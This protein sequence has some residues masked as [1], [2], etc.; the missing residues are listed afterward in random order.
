MSESEAL[1]RTSCRSR[2]SSAE[3]H[4][5]WLL[6]RLL[7]MSSGHARFRALDAAGLSFFASAFAARLPLIGSSISFC[8]AAALR[9]FLPFAGSAPRSFAMLRFRASI[10]ST[11]FSDFGRAFNGLAATVLID[12]LGQRSFV[13]ILKFLGLECGG[14]LIDDMPGEIEHNRV[15]E[16]VIETGSGWTI[17]SERE[18]TKRAWVGAVSFDRRAIPYS[19][20]VTGFCRQE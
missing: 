14:I 4:A 2:S 18:W 10:R 17:A 12:Q 7:A 8:P 15:A 11:T 13:V 3:V 9:G 16:L 6:I 20:V 5:L 1:E 19:K